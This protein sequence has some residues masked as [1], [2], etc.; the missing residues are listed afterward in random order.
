MA[1]GLPVSMTPVRLYEAASTYVRDSVF[2]AGDA[3]S[4]WRAAREAGIDYIL[5]GAPERRHY[6]A[7]VREFDRHPE[8][9]SAVFRNSATTIY[10]L[11]H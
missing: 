1:A 7:M 9:F 10:A 11:S 2:M 5:A 6:G 8:L 4:A 3:Q